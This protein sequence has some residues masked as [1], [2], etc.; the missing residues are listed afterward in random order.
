MIPCKRIRTG[1]RLTNWNIYGLFAT[2]LAI[3]AIPDILIPFIPKI[4]IW[5]VS[6]ILIT[7]S[8]TKIICNIFLSASSSGSDIFIFDVLKIITSK[9]MYRIKMI[10]ILPSCKKFATLSYPNPMKVSSG[11]F[12]IISTARAIDCDAARQIL[13]KI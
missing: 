3:L 12:F 6:T 10:V 13:L 2:A 5:S 8:G 9:M 1:V 11:V 7:V 4:A